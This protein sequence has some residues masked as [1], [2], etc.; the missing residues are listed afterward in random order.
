[1]VSLQPEIVIHQ[2]TDLPQGLAPARMGEAVNRNALIRSEGTRNLVAAS[3]RAGA[4]RM[5]AQSIAWAYAPGP[6]PHVESD[7]LDLHAD[8]ARAVSVGG[9]AILEEAVLNSPPLEGVVLRY[10]QIYGPGTGSEGPTVF[11]STACRCGRLG[12]I[13]GN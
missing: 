3:L 12:G 6:E 7:L 11:R 9:V 8:G 1:M 10:G 4:T 2:L 5:V 13:A